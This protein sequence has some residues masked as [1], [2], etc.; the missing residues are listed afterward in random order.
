MHGETPMP[1][2]PPS[3]PSTLSVFEN[4]SDLLMIHIRRKRA[5]EMPPPSHDLLTFSLSAIH[6]ALHLNSNDVGKK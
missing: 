3:L 1:L 4:F 2:H 5:K 6:Y